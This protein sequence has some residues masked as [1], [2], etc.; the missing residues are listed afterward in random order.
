MPHRHGSV[1]GE[2]KGAMTLN[3]VTSIL[4]RHLVT[5]DRFH[6]SSTNF[7]EHTEAAC[8]AKP[9]RRALELV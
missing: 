3:R 1:S 8:K 9:E 6:K 5:F 7:D 2:A 4:G